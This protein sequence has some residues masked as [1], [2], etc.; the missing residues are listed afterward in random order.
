VEFDG[1]GDFLQKASPAGFSG[2][3][4]SSF[5]ILTNE[6]LVNT[7]A[8]FFYSLGDVTLSA[9]QLRSVTQEPYLRFQATVQDYN[10]YHTSGNQELY[11]LVCPSETTI[12]DYDLYRDGSLL[13][14]DSLNGGTVADINASFLTIGFLQGAT[15]AN[16]FKGKQQELI[17]Y[18]S[19]KS[20]NRANI[21]TNIATF[22]DITL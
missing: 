9:G 16:T 7:D 2:K 6:T 22:Y 21:E 13:T 14:P 12:N 8:R 19:N 17:L 10:S 1:T 15:T 5:N 20:A 18:N 11:S 3:S 4:Q